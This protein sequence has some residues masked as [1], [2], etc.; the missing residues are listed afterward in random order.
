M[1]VKVKLFA[2]F[3]EDL[4][5]EREIEYPYEVPISTVLHDLSL[6]ESDI[7]ILLVNGI[8]RGTDYRLHDHDAVAVTPSLV[9]H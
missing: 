8:H 9:H 4:G 3:R 6:S 5:K 1:M 2:T 7:G